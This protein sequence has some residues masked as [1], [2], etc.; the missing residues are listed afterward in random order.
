MLESSQSMTF[1]L[2]QASRAYLHLAHKGAYRLGMYRNSLE[3][4]GLFIL[5]FGFSQWFWFT[6]T[7]SEIGF[8]TQQIPLPLRRYSWLVL[9]PGMHMWMYYCL[10]AKIR[11]ME[12]ENGEAITSPLLVLVLSVFPFFSIWYL[13]A[14]LNRHWAW[15]VQYQG[16]RVTKEGLSP[17]YAL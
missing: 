14:A 3:D 4:A 15:H 7:L 17:Q 13:Q 16:E 10:A 5:T 8:H 9:I 2:V 12:A 6:R 1:P 11:E